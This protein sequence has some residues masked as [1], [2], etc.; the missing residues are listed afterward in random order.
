[1]GQA[2]DVLGRD[3]GAL[4]ELVGIELVDVQIK[5]I[6]YVPRVQ[7]S[8]FN[9]MVSE[10]E[11]IAAKYRAEG[12]KISAEM[13]GKIDKERNRILSEA[14]RTAETIKGEAE[15][16]LVEAQ[17]EPD[18]GYRLHALAL[19]YLALDRRSE[20]DAALAELMQKHEQQWSYGIA[21]VFSYRN[22]ADRAFEWLDKAVEYADPGLS[23]TVVEPAFGNI[24][25]DPR[26]LPFLE[27][28][29]KSPAQLDAIEF[30]VTLPK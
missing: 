20:A 7:E 1:M 13:Q 10:R 15:A 17:K 16:A 19:V 18:E 2:H 29:G 21:S 26:W 22:E 5:S 27:S 11:Q 12:Q 8:V 24:H 23:D 28:I 4:H 9:R 6:N 30:K 3:P 25:D 14:Y